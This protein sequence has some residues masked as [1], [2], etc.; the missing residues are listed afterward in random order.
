MSNNKYITDL[1]NGNDSKDLR[2]YLSGLKDI[3]SPIW[4]GY[5]PLLLATTGQ[6]VNIVEYIL[7]LGADTS[8]IIS[9]SAIDIDEFEVEPEEAIVL[10]GNAVEEL[11]DELN[12][13]GNVSAIHISSKNGST[14]ITELLLKYN[15]NPNVYDQGKCTP[16]HWAVS[17]GDINATKLLIDFKANPNAQDIVGSTPLHEAVRRKNIAIIELLLAYDFDPNIK[18]TFDK[19][20]LELAA[21]IPVIY[22][23]ILNKTDKLPD[24]FSSH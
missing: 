14:K 19:S 20:A 1:I 12:N 17:K 3:N 22:N 2:E 5:N 13:L 23:L 18:D 11:V 8:S 4:R 15:A 24:G 21:D 10:D 9:S 7:D 16:L 6:N